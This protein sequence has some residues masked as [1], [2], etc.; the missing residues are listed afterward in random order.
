MVGLLGVF[1]LALLVAGIAVAIKPWPK[2]GMKSRWFALPLL[3]LSLFSCSAAMSNGE[4]QPEIKVV[5]GPPSIKAADKS[6]E[7]V[8]VA[9]PNLIIHAYIADPVSKKLVVTQAGQILEAVGKALKKGV[10]E[11]GPEIQ[12]ID[13]MTDVAIIDRLGNE[14]RR[15][16]LNISV[17]AA[18]LRAANY[19]NLT[20]F[21]VL[22]LAHEVGWST[23][24]GG[25]SA[26][27]WCEDNAQY[28]HGFC[29]QT[30]WGRASR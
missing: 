20:T 23:W 7:S 12:N 30:P 6:I 24:V 2:L 19:D 15:P 3:F 16:F 5:A 28:A 18:D 27:A 1:G 13:L 14:Q 10:A 26:E 21:G 17:S 4:G 9:G 8:E 22:N 11:D 29:V 25:E